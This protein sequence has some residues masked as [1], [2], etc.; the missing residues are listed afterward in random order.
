MTGMNES[1][2]VRNRRKLRTVFSMASA[3][4]RCIKLLDHLIVHS[5]Y[6]LEFFVC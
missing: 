6:C 3:V 2:A 1:E 5:L 4:K